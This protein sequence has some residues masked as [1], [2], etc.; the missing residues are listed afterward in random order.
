MAK[1]GGSPPNR[2]R[3]PEEAAADALRDTVATLNTQ[4]QHAQDL[5]IVTMLHREPPVP[6]PSLPQG[7]LY[8]VVAE[9]RAGSFEVPVQPT[10]SITCSHTRSV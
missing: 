1:P 9:I 6:A 2:A 5:G 7:F 3:S 10:L 4:L 8:D